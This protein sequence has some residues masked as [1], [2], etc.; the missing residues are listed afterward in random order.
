MLL[1]SNNVLLSVAVFTIL[2][3]TLYPLIIDV[4]GLGKLSVGAP[5][6]NQVFTPLAFLILFFMGISYLLNGSQADKIRHLKKSVCV[7]VAAI[8]VS[9]L[10]L[11]LLTPALQWKVMIGLTLTLWIIL[12]TLQMLWREKQKKMT[13]QKIFQTRGAMLLAHLGVA[14]SA[15]GII[16]S[17]AYSLQRDVRMRVGDTVPL[18]MY[19]FKLTHV[20][21]LRGPNYTGAEATLQL[22]NTSVSVPD[23]K[24]QLRYYPVSDIALSK[25]AINMGLWRDL[26]VALAEPVSPNAWAFRFYVKPFM[27]W[28]WM[29]GILMVAGGLCA[30]LQTKR[31]E[32]LRQIN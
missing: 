31:R 4:L 32:R 2:L 6:F 28:I 19:Q 3:G 16:L 13:L 10:L 26:Y 23:L 15:I 22:L 9:M 1:I 8:S 27:L 30:I 14:V 7:M 21:A 18:G 20:D 17:S 5:Y 24:S 12:N 29:G 25:P 11:L